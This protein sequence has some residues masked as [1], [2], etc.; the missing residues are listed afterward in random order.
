MKHLEDLR[1]TLC[2]EL[3]EIA[4][5][6][7]L[8]AGALDTVDKLAHTI[9][10]LDKV[11]MGEGYSSAGDWYAMGNYGERPGYRD[12]VSYRGRKRDSMGRY[13]RTDAKEDIA[14]KLRR[15]MDDAPDS[16]TREA[17]DKALRCMEE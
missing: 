1:D 16:R 9:K 10:N 6:G 7:E 17:L 12:S 15:M 14:D 2:R 11:M 3:D 13:S 5:K 8:S 4:G